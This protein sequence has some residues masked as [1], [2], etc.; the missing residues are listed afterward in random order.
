VTDAQ[1]L[2]EQR[3]RRRIDDLLR[4]AG[5]AVQSMSELDLAAARGVAVREFRTAMG[6]CDYL[7]FVD[8]KAIGTIEA[9]K[10]GETLRGV[11]PQSDRYNAGFQE[12]VKTRPVPYVRLPLPFHYMTTGAETLFTSRLDPIRRPREVFAFHRPETLLEW[13]QEEHSLRARIRHMP[14]VTQHSLHD[15]QIEAVEGLEASLRDDRPRSLVDMTMGAGKTFVAVDEVYRLLRFAKAERVVFLVDR[16]NLGEQ[17]EREFKNYVSPNDGRKFSELYN[18]QLLR[19]NRIDPAAQVVITTIQRLYSILRGQSD[20]EFDPTL[21]QES[22][23]ETQA[24]PDETALPV[25]YQPRVPI[26]T[27][28]FILTDECH[29]SI[30][31]KWGQVLDYFDAFLVGLTAT[32]SKFTYAYF[33]GNVVAEYSHQESVADGIN[34]DYTVYRIDTEV[35]RHGATIAAGEYVELRYKESRMRGL[36]ELED[37]ITYDKAKLDRAVVSPDQ[38][39]TVVRTFKAKVCTEIFPGREEVPKTIF[40]CKNDAHAEDVLKVI[41]E[42]FGRG[43]DFARKIT[44]KAQGSSAQHIQ[45]FRTDPNFRIAVSVDQISTGTDIKAVECLVFMRMIGERGLF[46]QMKGRGVRRIDDNEFWAVTPGAREQGARKDHFVIV[47]CVGITDEGRAWSETKPL[48]RKPTVPLKKL[49][50]DI[51]LGAF[52]PDTVST[53]G[54]RL[55]RLDNKL[56]AE[57][58]AEYREM[59]GVDLGGTAK[60][61]IEAGDIE[62]AMEL[63]ASDVVE[64]EP[65]EAEIEAAQRR[66]CEVAVEPLLSALVRTHLLE[67]QDQSEQVIDLATQ[68]ELLFAGYIDTGEA[69]RLTQTFRE[70]IEEH[71]D[72]YAALEAYY[73]EPYQRRLSYDEIKQLARAIE[74]PPLNLTREKLWA[75]YKKLDDSKVRGEGGRVLTDIVSLVRYALEVDE[76]LVPRVDVVCLRYDLW[77]SEQTQNGRKFTPEQARWLEMVR[78]HIAT[79]MTI[80]S[81]DFDLE[82][83]NEEGGINGAYEVFGDQL[84][85]LLQELNVTLGAA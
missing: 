18:V 72:E 62:R 37:E 30:Y 35:S 21:E 16:I 79:S 76:E 17:A 42:E 84:D 3:A 82:P 45:D 28:D 13:A 44:Y 58:R 43:S 24:G 83:F 85:P 80:E 19:S 34:V 52:T 66:L 68:D 40:F 74:K 25:T 77:M 15:H 26:E 38:I 75:A 81:D 32:P 1:L 50:E 69:E 33:H 46:E 5:W 61:L 14:P 36:K 60:A 71:H 64:R 54:A 10:E 55:K 9:K 63:A 23:F 48:D 20:E 2:P 73:L 56:S 41:L 53:L 7:L 27:F 31:G 39:R 4:Q 11:E 57:D 51:A 12:T 6:P 67:L 8:R 78:D 47:D 70:W 29:R 59:T 65:T 22:T 49:F